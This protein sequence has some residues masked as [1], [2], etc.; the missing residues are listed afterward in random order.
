MKRIEKAPASVKNII[1]LGCG[2]G[3]LG[4]LVANE[5]SWVE[6]LGV[7][8][9]QRMVEISRK[10]KSTRGSTVYASVSNDD[11]AKY[12]STLERQ[13]IDC[14]LASDV[15]IYIGN[16]S[17]VL[18]ETLEC[19]TSGGVVGFTVESYAGSN[20]DGLRLLPSGRFG[21]SRPYI[22]KAVRLN[23][24]E[25][26]SWDDCVLHHQGGANIRGSSV[27]LRKLQ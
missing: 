8:L 22:N 14:V 3:L 2:T 5:M 24:F 6:I 9:S 4:T 20:N 7:D 10:R 17:K 21:H 23:G 12:L 27:I 15:F 26:L 11:A 25:I 18:K 1:D 16:I 19:L 13:S